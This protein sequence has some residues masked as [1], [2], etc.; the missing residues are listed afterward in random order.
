MPFQTK[1][2]MLSLKDERNWT[3][4]L[5]LRKKEG[6]YMR[7]YILCKERI[8]KKSTHGYWSTKGRWSN[9]SSFLEMS[10]MYSQS[11]GIDFEFSQSC[12][13]SCMANLTSVGLN[14]CVMEYSDLFLNLIWANPDIYVRR[15][16]WWLVCW[17][18]PHWEKTLE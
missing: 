12:D 6:H 18:I 11:S 16:L 3:G 17:F 1:S 15:K 10:V 4:Y 2:S 13:N 7:E 14:M 9:K 8:E 5:W